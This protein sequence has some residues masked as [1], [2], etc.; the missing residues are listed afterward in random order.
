MDDIGLQ[1]GRALGKLLIQWISFADR[2]H[3]R[4]FLFFRNPNWIPLI[5][6]QN[7]QSQEEEVISFL[8]S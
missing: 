7:L 3:L 1:T 5:L 4:F 2:D 6:P 8:N